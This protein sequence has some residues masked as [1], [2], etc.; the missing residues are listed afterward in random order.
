MRE[1]EK[2]GREKRGKKKS[3]Q[4]GKSGSGQQMHKHQTSN[5]K[6]QCEGKHIDRLS[7]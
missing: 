5:I 6:Y 2:R 3:E 7:E 1:Q 4:G